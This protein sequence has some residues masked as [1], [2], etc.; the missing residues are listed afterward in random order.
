[1]KTN[2]L[3]LMGF[4]FLIVLGT[5]HN[6]SHY[7]NSIPPAN[8]AKIHLDAIISSS[9][10]TTIKNHML[11]LKLKLFQIDK[12]LPENKNPVWFFPTQSTDFQQIR[13]NVVE[14]ISTLDGFSDMQNDSSTYHSGML[15]IKS[16][17]VILKENLSDSEAFL[18]WSPTNIIF[19]G[20]WVVGLIGFTKMCVKIEKR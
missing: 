14:M 16:R 5:G 8:T 12:I 9:D 1:M 17:S 6:I 20:I 15:D 2:Q 18:Y 19:T 3:I 4:A 11:E 7:Q 10:P 13:N